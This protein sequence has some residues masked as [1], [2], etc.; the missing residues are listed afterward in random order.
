MRS[1]AP[2]VLKLHGGR[3]VE[4]LRVEHLSGGWIRATTVC[5]RVDYDPELDAGWRTVDRLVVRSYSP[6]EVREIVELEAVPS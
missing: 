1:E 6:T 4:A 3:R 5:H 2:F